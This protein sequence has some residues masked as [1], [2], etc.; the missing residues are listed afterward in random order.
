MRLSRLLVCVIT[1]QLCVYVSL[2]ATCEPGAVCKTADAAAKASSTCTK[3]EDC[4]A[5]EQCLANGVC[6]TIGAPYGDSDI[7][8]SRSEIVV[9]QNVGRILPCTLRIVFVIITVCFQ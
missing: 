1:L 6:G 4:P 2:A 5:G 9:I 8:S 3:A 7:V